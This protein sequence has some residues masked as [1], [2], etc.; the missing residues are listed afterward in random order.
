MLQLLLLL[1]LGSNTWTKRSCLTTNPAAST[2]RKKHICWHQKSMLWPACFILRQALLAFARSKSLVCCVHTRRSNRTSFVILVN[3]DHRTWESR[4]AGRTLSRWLYRI[5]IQMPKTTL[6]PWSASISHTHCKCCREERH[7][8]PKPNSRA[9][10]EKKIWW[11]HRWRRSRAQ[12]GGS[13][14]HCPEL[15]F[16]GALWVEIRIAEQ[17]GD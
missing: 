17:N 3:V 16:C 4:T 9:R 15:D 5:E 7:G 1:G 10:R 14:R 8:T 6:T 12:S 11:W 2:W 13:Y